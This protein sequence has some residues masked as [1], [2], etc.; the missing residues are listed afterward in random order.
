M[1]LKMTEGDKIKSAFDTMRHI[2]ITQGIPYSL[3]F[4]PSKK[5]YRL[6][7]M[8]KSFIHTDIFEVM[9]DAIKYVSIAEGLTKP[10]EW[11]EIPTK[12]FKDE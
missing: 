6:R 5:I 10:N 12:P 11:E 8:H 3:E 7:T 1:M 9:K 4:V 2:S